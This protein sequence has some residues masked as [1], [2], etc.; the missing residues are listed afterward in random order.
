M[1]FVGV[2][3]APRAV[4][5]MSSLTLSHDEY[6][7]LNPSQGH[8]TLKQTELYS[9]VTTLAACRRVKAARETAFLLETFLILAAQRRR[10]L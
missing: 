4:R 6:R 1:K 10:K 7:C 2:N 9:Y 8:A 3:V 5:D